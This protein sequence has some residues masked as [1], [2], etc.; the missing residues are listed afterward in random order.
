[1]Q[2]G[3]RQKN[4]QIESAALEKMMQN[5][6]RWQVYQFRSYYYRSK[7]ISDKA[8]TDEVNYL[9]L[10]VEWLKETL[11]YSNSEKDQAK[12]KTRIGNQY[13]RM[14]E[15]FFKNQQY[16]KAIDN[17]E[18][19]KQYFT[20]GNILDYRIKAAMQRLNVTVEPANINLRPSQ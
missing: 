2:T 3:I 15:L 8:F 18:K 1:M 10:H 5:D 11:K 14:G 16:V 4:P 7:G 9:L 12:L 6:V 13:T 20:S 17:F 19:A